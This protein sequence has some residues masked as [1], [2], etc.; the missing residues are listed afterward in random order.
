MHDIETRF[1]RPSRNDDGECLEN[2]QAQMFPQL[3]K[4]I[5]G[6]LEFELTPTEKMQAHRCVLFNCNAVDGLVR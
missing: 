5:G 6:I 3:G 1:N 4:P 2:S